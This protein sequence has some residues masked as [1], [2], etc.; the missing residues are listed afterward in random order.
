ML[1]TSHKF[2]SKFFC[3]KLR[4]SFSL[5]TCYHQNLYTSVSRTILRPENKIAIYS[6]NN[7]LFCNI[8]VWCFI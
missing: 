6:K 2:I 3:N 4:T 8:M 7:K 1:P 5:T